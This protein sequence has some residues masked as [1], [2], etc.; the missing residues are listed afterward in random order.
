MDL[1]EV[2]KTTFAAREFTDE[3]VDDAT[4]FRIL[5]QARFAPSGGNRQPWKVVVVKDAE[6]RKRAAEAAEPT[7]RRYM[8]QVVAGENPW[9]TIEPTKLTPEEIANGPDPA[10]YLASIVSAPAVLVVFA[11]LRVIASFDSEQDRVG[12]ISGASIYP[13]VWNVLLAARNEGLGGTLT[14]FVGG[15]DAEVQAIFGMADYMV[16]AALLPIGRPVKQLTK[17]KR[18]GVDEIATIDHADGP[19]LSEPGD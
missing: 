7:F 13:F 5:D 3:P 4:L 1:T 17:L 11:D 16:P 9:N 2:M 14:T 18:N 12:V 8:A 10:G 15:A 6:K 19:R